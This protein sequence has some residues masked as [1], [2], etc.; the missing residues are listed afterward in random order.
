L[1]LENGVLLSLRLTPALFFTS[2]EL[3]KVHLILTK[4][5][6]DLCDLA[7]L[8]SDSL[9]RAQWVARVPPKVLTQTSDVGFERIVKPNRGASVV[10]AD[11][12]QGWFNRHVH[13]ILPM[14]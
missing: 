3:L 9:L 7:L 13:S 10:R 5:R 4:E 12:Q 14:R 8:V 1:V 6:P 11:R 2:V